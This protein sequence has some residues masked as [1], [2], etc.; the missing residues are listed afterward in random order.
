MKPIEPQFYFLFW[1]V[2][3][4]WAFF[5]IWG[6]LQQIPSQAQIIYF[7]VINLSQ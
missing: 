1:I 6:K 3:F 4:I 5:C 2:F 7:K